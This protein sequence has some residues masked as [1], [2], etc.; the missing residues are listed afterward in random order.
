MNNEYIDNVKLIDKE[1]KEIFTRKVEILK[2]NA[3]HKSFQVDSKSVLV[4]KDINF[5]IKQGESIVLL[6]ASGCGKSTLL[7]L[8]AGL[9]T[10]YEGDLFFHDEKIKGTSVKRGMAFQE[11]RLFPWLTIEE[12]IEFGLK[13]DLEKCQKKI[14]VEEHMEL[15]G[16]NKFKNALPHQLSGGMQQR[17]SIARALVNK[18]E[19]LLL[20][21]PF[22]ALDALTRTNM[23]KELLKIWAREKITM[24]LVTHDIEEA[25][26]LA[27]RIFVMTPLPGTIAEI[28]NVDIDKNDKFTSKRIL[29]LKN[30]IYNKFFSGN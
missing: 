16:L 19:I 13:K 8:I 18:P 7:R 14:V 3:I 22:G 17:V 28:I 26:L 20:D 12:N 5:T 1:N 25:I 2:C 9:D 15:V 10:E 30:Y 11:P 27:D 6:G 29:E 23:Q 4:L 21:E 24:I